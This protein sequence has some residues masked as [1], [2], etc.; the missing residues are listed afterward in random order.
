MKKFIF[1]SHPFKSNPE[2]NRVKVDKI[3][4]YLIKHDMV[5]VSPLHMFSFYGDD[6]DRGEI[7]KACKH[8]IDM[9]DEVWIYG[10]SKGCREEANYAK[11]L[12]KH[13]EICY[14]QIDYKRLMEDSRCLGER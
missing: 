8:L 1:V 11:A 10:D 13:I 7:M 14:E 3:C 2:L 6:T 12:G 5:P 9:C 4:K